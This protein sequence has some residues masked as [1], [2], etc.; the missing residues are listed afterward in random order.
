MAEIERD[1]IYRIKGAAKSD[2]QFQFLK[3][4]VVPD[5]VEYER[6]GDY[7]DAPADT[8]AEANAK[9]AQ[10]PENKAAAKPDSK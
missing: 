7:P 4:H 2:G 3:G 5:G 10:A 8:V 9:A 1:G 6:V